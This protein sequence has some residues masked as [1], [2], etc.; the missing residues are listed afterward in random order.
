MVNKRN[1]FLSCLSDFGKT[2]TEQGLLPANHLR[3]MSS[4]GYLSSTAQ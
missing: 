2:S 4:L 1:A 3:T